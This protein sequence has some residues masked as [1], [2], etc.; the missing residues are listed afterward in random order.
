MHS[1]Y[2]EWRTANK[3]KIVTELLVVYEATM[4]EYFGAFKVLDIVGPY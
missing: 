1:E 3:P 2:N 4:R